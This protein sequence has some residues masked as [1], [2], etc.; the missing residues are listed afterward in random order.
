MSEAIDIAVI[1]LRIKALTKL[2]QKEGIVVPEG[3]I[4]EL[5]KKS[6]L[7]IMKRVEARFGTSRSKIAPIEWIRSLLRFVVRADPGS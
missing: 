3:F 4:S 7:E 1:L 5:S 6:D 2:A